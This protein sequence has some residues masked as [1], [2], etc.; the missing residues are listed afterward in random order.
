LTSA[1]QQ[2]H[3]PKASPAPSESERGALYELV[4]LAS[5]KSTDTPPA[6]PPAADRAKLDKLVAASTDAM[7]PIFSRAPAK[8]PL[9]QP[10]ADAAPAK[11]PVRVASLEPAQKATNEAPAAPVT[12]AKGLGEGWAPAPDF[13]EDHPEEVSYRPFPIAPLLTESA[14]ADDAALVKLVP[15]DVARTLD[16]LDDRPVVLP[17]RLR[18]GEQKAEVAKAQQFRG[19]AVDA[20][21]L[22]PGRV[23]TPAPAPASGSTAAAEPVRTP[24]Q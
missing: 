4:S 17:L 12:A 9:G 13:D 5:L 1:P 22:G 7:P 15:P 18:S 11:E 23:S 3:A 16:L 19:D 8:P 6:S 14:S 20:S 24:A 21:A 10:L 2:R